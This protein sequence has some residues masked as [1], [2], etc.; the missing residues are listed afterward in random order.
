MNKGDLGFIIPWGALFLLLF[1]LLGW[2]G[3][4]VWLIALFVRKK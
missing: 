1:Y 2:A 4:L 3:I